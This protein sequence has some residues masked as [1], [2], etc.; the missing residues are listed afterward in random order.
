MSIGRK[1]ERYDFYFIYSAAKLQDFDLG[2]LNIII[3][4]LKTRS[5]EQQ[6]SNDQVSNSILLNITV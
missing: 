3:V 5:I 4:E 1:V 2:F 6:I